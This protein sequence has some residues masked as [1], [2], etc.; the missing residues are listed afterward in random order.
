MVGFPLEIYDDPKLNRR[1]F[2][3]A[4]AAVILPMLAEG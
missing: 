2:S 3:Q 1:E 4:E